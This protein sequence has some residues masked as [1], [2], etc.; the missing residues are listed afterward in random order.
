MR[1]A[2][3]AS[4]AVAVA[5]YTTGGPHTV[6]SCSAKAL[7]PE[8]APPRTSTR[9][10]ATALER[11]CPRADARSLGG[12][13][14]LEVANGLVE[15]VALVNDHVVVLAYPLHLT[16]RRSHADAPL[17]FALGAPGSQTW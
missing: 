2:I 17:T 10:Q 1:S 7:L 3:S 11:D 14:G 13:D 8:R 15:P 9:R 6:A 16:L 12:D 4:E 5:T